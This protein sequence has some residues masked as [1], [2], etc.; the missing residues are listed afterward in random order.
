[1]TPDWV[2]GLRSEQGDAERS[3]ADESGAAEPGTARS[4]AEP[5]AVETSGPLAG[6]AGLLSPQ[7]VAGLASRAEFKP[8]PPVPDEQHK[9]A[10]R[11]REMLNEPPARPALPA[12]APGRPAVRAL[13]RWLIYLALI[14]VIVA[15]MF[16]P[17][18]YERILPPET[19]AGQNVYNTLRALPPGSEVLLVVDYD[20][21]H[22]GE[23][24]P[25][26][27]A[28]LW[29]LVT[30]GQRVLVVSHTPQGVAIVQDLI[31]S[32]ALWAYGPAPA[33]GVHTLNLGYLP[34]HP[35]VMQAF[36][37]DPIGNAALWGTDALPK[38]TELGRAIAQFTDLDAIVLVSASQEH[39]RWWIEQTFGS[40]PVHSLPMLAGLSASIAPALLPYSAPGAQLSGVLVGLAGAA[41]Y[42]TLSGARFTPNARQNMI[43]QGSAQM[44]LAAIV[45]VSGISAALRAVASG[46]KG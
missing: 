6:L 16:V 38:E 45:L 42:E 28:L 25:L 1:V 41:E 23:L 21:A 17:A 26:T 8:E 11:V 12:A 40:Q 34:P 22:D 39:T 35:A 5:G 44:L 43:L 32:R 36:M 4:A 19:E 18:L 30:S 24:T 37:A 9:L 15:A 33:A 20:A 27:R 10:A 3:D 31:E 46:R 2:R 14:A 7:P 29:H 13:G